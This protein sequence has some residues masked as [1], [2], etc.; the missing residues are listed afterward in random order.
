[1]TTRYLSG[2]YPGGYTLNSNY[3]GLVIESTASVGG[4]GVVAT[5][6]ASIAN[7]GVV[8][9]TTSFGILLYAGGTVTN[10]SETDKM[11][12]ISG[13][14]GIH[15]SGGP[16]T[17]TNY[18]TIVGFAGG[19]AGV[20]LFRGGLVT[21]GSSTDTTATIS[22]HVG[23]S[24]Q[25]ARATVVNFG[26]IQ[27]YGNECVLLEDGGSVIN[28]SNADTTALIGGPNTAY[29]VNSRK[30]A[31]VT[32]F[33]T[34]Y[35]VI[36]FNGTVINGSAADTTALISGNIGVFG[37]HKV[38][39]FGTITTISLE[40]SATLTNGS[41]DDTAALISGG[42][43]GAVITNFG[44]IASAHGHAVGV[45]GVLINGSAADTTALVSGVGGVFASASAS[46]TVTNFGTIVGT[47]GNAL[48]FN[49][50]KC[51]LNIEAGC[52]FVGGV[53]GHGGVLDLASG[54]GVVRGLGDGPV[55]VTG[56]MQRTVFRQ[57][58]TLEIAA[59]ARFSLAVPGTVANGGFHTLVD[60]GLFTVNDELTISG[61]LSGTGTLA[62]AAG[63]TIEID[64]AAPSTLTTKFNGGYSV[65]ALMSPS[66]FA[67]TISGLVVGDTIDLLGITATSATVAP[68]DRLVVYDG[69]TQVASLQLAGSYNGATFDV[70][71]DGKG[72]TDVT[73][74][75]PGAAPS[76]HAFISA[77]AGFGAAASVHSVLGDFRAAHEPHVLTSPRVA[78]A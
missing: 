5:S 75:T 68:K 7:D 63:A 74:A 26:T 15:A 18:G 11:A 8:A 2:A 38:I 25:N 53:F 16:T 37:G 21:N 31:T 69:T 56:S 10:G 76:P 55:I 59:G 14:V 34:I 19:A 45:G 73:L 22:G 44:T 64:S 49:D 28:G 20:G 54:V 39:N 3:S 72:G 9:S 1:M 48:K 6:R 24:V 36:S 50:A 13:K 17:V 32:N 43:G 71:A 40:S 23:V 46:A 47:G 62:M 52:A 42:V 4:A 60:N 29:G 67:A 65:L 70:S 66:S 61:T 41:V 33:G 58:R 57:F 12:L 77:M 30:P 35:G 27:G 51:T 78:I